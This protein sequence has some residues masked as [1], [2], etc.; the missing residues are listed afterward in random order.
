MFM[1]FS[2]WTRLPCRLL[3]C[4]TLRF[5]SRRWEITVDIRSVSVEGDFKLS[6]PLVIPDESYNYNIHAVG[7]VT[8]VQCSLNVGGAVSHWVSRSHYLCL[9]IMRSWYHESFSCPSTDFFGRRSACGNKTLYYETFPFDKRMLDWPS[10]LDDDQDVFREWKECR[11][12]ER[13]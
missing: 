8:Y 7:S 4:N 3:Q 6:V 11:C 5:S 9:W 1:F 12:Q 10:F 2:Q 13:K